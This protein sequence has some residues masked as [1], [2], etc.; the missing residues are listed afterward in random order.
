MTPGTAPIAIMATSPQGT[1]SFRTYGI[2][3]TT[4]VEMKNASEVPCASCWE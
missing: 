2:T 4:A 3:A 1:E